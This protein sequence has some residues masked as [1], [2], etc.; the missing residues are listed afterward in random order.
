MPYETQYGYCAEEEICLDGVARDERKHYAICV[1][2]AGLTPKNVSALGQEQSGE[3]EVTNTIQS[4]IK[5]DR[6]RY[7][8]A[9]IVVMEDKGSTAIMAQSLSLNALIAGNA[10]QHGDLWQIPK[11]VG[12][13][14]S[15]C[16]QVGLASVPPT[17]ARL[18]ADVRL[19]DHTKSVRLYVVVVEV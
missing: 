11:A 3:G 2:L 7:I 19:Q 16:T 13:R 14:C 1:N 10:Q 18:S 8:A 5:V 15:N 4:A 9:Q 12:Q 17:A 6:G